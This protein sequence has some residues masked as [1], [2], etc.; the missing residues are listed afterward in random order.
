MFFKK[1]FFYCTAAAS[2]LCGALRGQSVPADR[3]TDWSRPGTHAPFVPVRVSDMADFSADASG[4]LPCDSSLQAAL[5][6]LGGPGRVL[7]P[8]GTY[9]FNHTVVLPDSVILEGAADPVTL[10]STVLLRFNPGGTYRQGLSVQGTETDLGIVPGLPLLQG[11]RKIYLPQAAAHVRPGDDIRLDARDD[12]S[13]VYST[14]ALHATGQILRVTAVEGDSLL[15]EKPLR[16]S[17]SS[18]R[19]PH[20]F[21]RRP[22][23]QVHIKC[24]NMERVDATPEQT[25]NILFDNAVDCS[26]AG[27]ESLRCNF[28]HVNIQN[29]SYITVENCHFKEAFAYGDGGQGYGVLLQYAASDCYVYANTFTHLR[30]SMLL[31]SGANG[32]VSAYNYSTDPYWSQTFLPANSAG[33]MVLHG[34]YPYMNLF[35]GNVVQNIVV[36]N[37]HGINGPLNTFFRNRAELY[38]I[39]MNTSPASPRQNFIGNQVSNTTSS[40]YGLYS[41]QGAD[42]FAYGNT[43][44]GSI[45]PAGTSE[46]ADATMFGY[47]FPSYYTAFSSVP[48]IRAAN[49]QS[50]EPLTETAYRYGTGRLS[51]CSGTEYVNPYLSVTEPPTHVFSVY[52]NPSAG[53]LHI[54]GEG[55]TDVEVWDM[56]GRR[57]RTVPF[58][59]C[60]DFSDLQPGSYV[61]RIR[62]N[63]QVLSGKWVVAR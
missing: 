37:S 41:L 48:P 9:L 16:R 15:L 60:M 39:F 2:V 13:L 35:E 11:M 22:R 23:R 28:A 7:F 12:S 25:A 50:A 5:A 51:V 53:V 63:G 19:P 20:V 56:T 43:V 10:K 30:H 54:P 38:G 24:M 14:W 49:W 57:C 61:L 29:A 27:M 44:K 55:I 42:H 21:L 31:Q 33:D 32:N 62:Q 45:M 26:L 3:I 40:L 17:Y 58:T 36:D 1:P 4:T 18:A 34:N 6:A 46:Y 52:P 8:A 47:V 59:E